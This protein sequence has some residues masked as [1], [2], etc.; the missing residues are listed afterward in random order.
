[1]VCGVH[2]SVKGVKEGLDFAIE[3]M[4]DG[5][6]TIYRDNFSPIFIQ[7]ATEDTRVRGESEQRTARRRNEYLEAEARHILIRGEPTTGKGDQ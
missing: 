6:S 5:S 4:K 1:M 7:L 3:I 2:S